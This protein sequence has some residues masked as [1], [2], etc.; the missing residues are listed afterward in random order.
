MFDSKASHGSTGAG[1]SLLGVISQSGSSSWDVPSPTHPRDGEEEA[2]IDTLDLRPP[3]QDQGG[4][5]HSQAPSEEGGGG[6]VSGE[7]PGHHATM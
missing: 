1:G 2:P 4:S 6:G 3:P 7:T 5:V